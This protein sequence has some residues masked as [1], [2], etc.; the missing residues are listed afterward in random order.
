MIIK[1]DTRTNQS[2]ESKRLQNAQPQMEC[3]EIIV[4]ERQK[5]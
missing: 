5:E 2:E 3:L 1:T 4:E